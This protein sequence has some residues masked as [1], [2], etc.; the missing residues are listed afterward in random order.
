[1]NVI[2]KIVDVLTP[3]Y[4]TDN[5]HG[6]WW[7]CPRINT[8]E[9]A[10]K[11]LNMTDD[12]NYTKMSLKQFINTLDLIAKMEITNGF[13]NG[14]NYQLP[15]HLR[16]MGNLER[17]YRLSSEFSF[18]KAS[19][20]F[21]EHIEF[22]QKNRN[23]KINGVA[24]GAFN[25]G[26]GVHI[27]SL[28]F[29]SVIKSPALISSLIKSGADVNKGLKKPH[30]ASPLHLVFLHP[31]RFDHAAE[32]TYS[33]FVHPKRFEHA[34]ELTDSKTFAK[35]SSMIVECIKVLIS[36][37]CNP[38]TI[39]T[40]FSHCRTPDIS[41]S[42]YRY[43]NGIISLSSYTTPLWWSLTHISN[44]YYNDPNSITHAEKSV[45]LL[46][47]ANADIE[48]ENSGFTP[49]QYVFKNHCLSVLVGRTLI[50]LGADV[51]K[52]N[53]NGTAFEMSSKQIC[54]LKEK[55]SYGGK[56][57]EVI[58]YFRDYLQRYYPRLRERLKE[59]LPNVLCDIV[60]EYVE[61]T[62]TEL[63]FTV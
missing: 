62:E 49:L 13:Y 58:A 12:G 38:N 16:N 6:D 9:R 53:G 59:K 35:E 41:P 29:A 46:I 8:S 61:E 54:L 11:F 30:V 43:S 24:S 27:T 44:S 52:K 25:S 28:G 15:R 23:F 1:M 14:Y 32:L 40:E 4:V 36:L 21:V 18:D 31:K 37:G 63:E 57:K 39:C 47:D 22:M 55:C 60:I 48:C 10:L 3:N 20:V 50:G 26:D 45:K 34:K 17:C 33:V 7:G 51:H 2:S 19:Q 5:E 42:T 56:E